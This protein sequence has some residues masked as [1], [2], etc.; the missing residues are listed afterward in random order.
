MTDIAITQQSDLFGPI[1]PPS[2]NPLIGLAV[3][4]PTPCRCGSVTA[5]IGSSKN[6]H[7]AAC[8]CTN[9]GSFTR[10][11]S[12]EVVSF[13]S[14]TI[15]QFGPPS[16]PIILRGIITGGEDMEKKYDNSGALFKNDRK[17]GEKDRD[18]SGSITI[19]GREYWLSGW[20]KQGKQAK[21]IGL[22]AK[23]KDAATSKP[24]QTK[25]LD[26]EIPF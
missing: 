12:A 18:Y 19:D 10:W 6:Q 9:C 8:R 21:F 14:E 7:A 1:T 16:E 23:P 22:T 26:D 24:A 17:D 25:E 2:S 5:T 4:L 11:L 20:I 3:V 15:Q 13:I